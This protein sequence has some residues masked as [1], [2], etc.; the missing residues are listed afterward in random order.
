MVGRETLAAQNFRKADKTFWNYAAI[1]RQLVHVS[2]CQQHRPAGN[3]DCTLVSAH[4]MGLGEQQSGGSQFVEVGCFDIV[5]AHG[6]KCMVAVVISIDDDDVFSSFAGLG[7]AVARQK[8][9]QNES[10]FFHAER[11]FD[12]MVLFQMTNASG[13]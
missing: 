10:N 12:L 9:E 11:Y 3:A 8:C 4:D 6:T 13:K 5:I 2:S 7:K 1:S